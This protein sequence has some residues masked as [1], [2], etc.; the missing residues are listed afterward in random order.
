[1]VI[2]PVDTAGAVMVWSHLLYIAE[3]NPQL[4]DGRFYEHLD[5]DPLKESQNM[6]KST[7]FEMITDNQRPPS[8]PSRFY[9]Y[10]LPTIHKAGNPGRPNNCFCV[11][12]SHRKHSFHLDQIM[13]PLVHNL[14]TYVNQW[15]PFWQHNDSQTLSLH[16]GHKSNIYCYPIPVALKRYLISSTSIPFSTHLQEH[17]RTL[18]SFFWVLFFF[19][20]M[21]YANLSLFP[22]YLWLH[23]WRARPKTFAEELKPQESTFV[24]YFLLNIPLL[25]GT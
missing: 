17:T 18:Q 6:V 25:T 20:F 5:H 19:S 4:S 24:H 14:S 23:W 21:T 2:K 11:L 22:T 12:L 15:F 7:I 10:L 9:M 1:M 8:A 13:C 16:H 3:A